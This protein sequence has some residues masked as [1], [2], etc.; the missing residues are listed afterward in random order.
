MEDYEVTLMML[1]CMVDQEKQLTQQE[2]AIKNLTSEMEGIM[3]A[4][5]DDIAA[6]EASPEAGD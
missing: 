6:L 5:S 1:K 4:F 2:E 3:A